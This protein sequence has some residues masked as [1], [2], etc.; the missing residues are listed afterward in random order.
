MNIHHSPVLLQEVLDF[1]G[2]EKEGLFID[3]TMGE[4]GH[5]LA[6]LEKFP[7]VN[8]I[9]LD[10][11]PFIQAKAKKRLE[12]FSN[13][14]QWVNTW[15]DDFFRSNDTGIKAQG[16][17]IDLGISVYH[18][19]ESGRGFSFRGDENLDMRL[20]P[21][22]G[23]SAAQVLNEYS[24]DALVQ[25][26]QD[27]GQ[28]R[29]ARKIARRIVQT[30][31]KKPFSKV[32]EL[33]EA[34]WLSYPPAQ[35]HKRLHPATKTF[36]ALRIEV[37]QELDRLDRVLE[38]VWDFLAPQGRLGIITFHSLED[39][40]VKVQFRQKAQEKGWSLLTKKPVGPSEE[41]VDRNPPSRSAKLRV[42]Q[43]EIQ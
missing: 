21:S 25:I 16:I 10:R 1:L 42:I 12:G 7:L 23:I 17:L 38:G 3:G 35:R 14:V 39:R 20:D 30:R 11:D 5:S 8:I 37:N 6:I 24:Q 19:E 36:Q 9:G 34:V 43:K 31:D 41:E 29:L 32:A 2:P 13:R 27:Y 33:E 4:G 18:Y 40:R 22:E 28:E 15:F 26:L